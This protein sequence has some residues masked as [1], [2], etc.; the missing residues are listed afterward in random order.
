MVNFMGHDE[1]TTA[2]ERSL[3]PAAKLPDPAAQD[4]MRAELSRIED[5]VLKAFE[6]V[7]I[8]ADR[9]EGA[10]WLALARTNTQLG[11]MCAKR[12]LYEGRRVG[13]P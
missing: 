1:E 3:P 2:R 9:S 11:F 4:A 12:A 5:A 10:R 7:A 13:D 6:Q 8:G